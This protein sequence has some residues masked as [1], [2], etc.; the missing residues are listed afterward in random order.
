MK[1]LKRNLLSVTKQLNLLAQRTGKIAKELN[2]LEKAQAAVKVK[3]KP[4]KKRVVKKAA[5]KKPAGKKTTRITASDTVLAI[6]KK[7]KKGV[8]TA[9]VKK[10]T[11][12][13]DSK[14]RVIIYRLKKQ[15]TI[16]NTRRG[17]YVKA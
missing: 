12:F 10:K 15:G 8:D 14:I 3:T 13:N 11:G 1:A 17:F 5:A 16:K 6:V 7:S 4:V 2:K 9:T